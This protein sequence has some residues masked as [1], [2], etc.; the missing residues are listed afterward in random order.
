VKDYPGRNS[1]RTGTLLLADCLTASAA[2][3]TFF[4]PWVVP[5]IEGELVDG[6]TGV[7]GNPVYQACVEAFIYTNAYSPD[8][9]IIV[10]VGTGQFLGHRRPTWLYSWLG[11]LLA[12]LLRSPGEQ[13][14]ELVDRHFPKATFYRIDVRLERDFSIDGAGEVAALR[15]V[16]ERLAARIDWANVLDGTDHEWRVTRGRR[17]PEGYAQ[18]V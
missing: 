2:A 6:G 1:T 18:A 14:T 10:S 15:D 13:Q 11:W 17:R 8:D 3:P 5:G 16:G 7:T 4:A 9:S 12:E